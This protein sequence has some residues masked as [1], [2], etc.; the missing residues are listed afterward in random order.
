MA[1]EALEHGLDR[2][3]RLLPGGGVGGGGQDEIGQYRACVG[4]GG[5]LD[6]DEGLIGLGPKPLVNRGR[7]VALNGITGLPGRCQP[8]GV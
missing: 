5:P 4:L 8:G 1:E 6:R 7:A 3:G 2:E